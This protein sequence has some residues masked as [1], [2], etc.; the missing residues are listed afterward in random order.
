M[1]NYAHAMREIALNEMEARIVLAIPHSGIHVRVQ[2]KG[3]AYCPAWEVTQSCG[4]HVAIRICR[5]VATISCNMRGYVESSLAYMCKAE[6]VRTCA[7]I[8]R[9]RSY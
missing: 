6:H 3:H 5:D 1:R 7:L 8:H 2:L 4:R 9:A